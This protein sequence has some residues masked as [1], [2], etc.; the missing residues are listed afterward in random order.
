MSA[1]GGAGGNRNRSPLWRLSAK[2]EVREELEHHVELMARRLQEEEGLDPRAAHAEALRR[3]GDTERVERDCRRIAQARNRRWSV[4]AW[5]ADLRQDVGFSMRQL[6]RSPAFAISLLAILTLGIG[7]NLA[8]F[9]ILDQALLAPL[10]FEESERIVTLWEE[11]ESRTSGLNVVGPANFTAWTVQSELLESTA[12]Y[13]TIERN[14]LAADASAQPRRVKARI[15]TDGYF[16][17]L[18]VQALEGRALRPEDYQAAA[19]DVVVL[20]HEFWISQFGGRSSVLGETVRLNGR[21]FEIVGVLPPDA[22]LDGGSTGGGLGAVPDLYTQ[23]PTSPAWETA[24]GRWLLVVGK[25]EQGYTAEEM[26]QEMEVLS[27]RQRERFPDFNGGW[28]GVVVPLEE[29]VRGMVRTPTQTAFL[30]VALVLVIVSINVASLLVA[31]AGTRRREIEVRA[32]LGA[33]RGRILRQVVAEGVALSVAGGLLGLGFAVLVLRGLQRLVPL[34]WTRDVD[35]GLD[36]SLLGYAAVL[37]LGCGLLFGL[38][39]ALHA[40]RSRSGGGGRSSASSIRRGDR[41]LRSALV[42]AETA[43]AVV[44]LIVSGLLLHS[45]WN[46]ARIDPGFDSERVLAATMD[47]AGSGLVQEGDDASVVYGALLSELENLPGV[48]AA[49]AVNSVPIAG[50]GY[51]T[52][53]WALDRPAPDPAQRLSADIRIMAGDYLETMGIRLVEGRAFDG[54][55]R[56]DTTRVALMD[57]DTAR[58]LWPDESPLGKELHVN[59]GDGSPRLVVGV[60]PSIRNRDLRQAARPALY[61]PH[62]QDPTGEMTLV[63]RGEGA[64]TTLAS[65]LREVVARV[66]PGVPLDDIGPLQ[67]A[68]ARTVEQDRLLSRALLGFAVASL[69]LAGLGLYSVTSYVVEQRRGEMAVRLAL[70]ATG[71]RVARLIIGQCVVMVAAGLMLGIAAAVVTTRSVPLDLFEVDAVDPATYLI[72]AVVLGV[73]ALAAAAVPAWRAATTPPARALV[74]D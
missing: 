36:A 46:T 33:S 29:H 42:V 17:V 69:L 60:V 71:L 31:R 35:P 5:F 65:S 38:A 70:G 73:G 24:R 63:L 58:D 66:T 20:G 13:L 28:Q 49:G 55:D 64:A 11:H 45:V 9:S 61:F 54:R 40:W 4:S 19:A 21:S 67:A 37:V 12:A 1:T 44:L 14:F 30:A 22:D 32:A 25:L 18:G 48:R 39:P 8:G 74:E 10:P 7:V 53:F 34:R 26:A 72:V 6:R 47:I 51:A 41:R 50:P 16:D 57:E 43:L 59:W 3:F 56:A 27:A 52:S 15:V 68:V 2:R 62:S 23:L